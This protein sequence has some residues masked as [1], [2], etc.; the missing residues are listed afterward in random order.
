[1]SGQQVEITDA[2]TFTDL[3]SSAQSGNPG[4]LLTLNFTEG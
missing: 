2:L 1:M 3:L 4:G